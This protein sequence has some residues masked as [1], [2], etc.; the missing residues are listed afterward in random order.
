[1]Q[2]VS[3]AQKVKSDRNMK[4]A[5]EEDDT[6]GKKKVIKNLIYNGF[7]FTYAS[8]YIKKQKTWKDICK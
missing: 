5:M 7:I 3:N 6:S 8:W 1:M 2:Q 4:A